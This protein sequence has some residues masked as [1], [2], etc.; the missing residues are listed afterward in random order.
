[1]DRF[2]PALL[3]GQEVIRVNPNSAQGYLLIGQANEL[4]GKPGEA[5]DNY[6]KAFAA[7][8]KTGQTELAAITR[9]RIAM[10]MQTMNTQIESPM[11]PTETP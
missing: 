5:L 11:P 3:D 2:E 8:E 9:T 7:A 6:D 4:L 1:M 10:L